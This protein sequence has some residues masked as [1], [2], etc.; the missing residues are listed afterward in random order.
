MAIT[1]PEFVQKWTASTRTERAAAQEHFVDLCESPKRALRQVG[2]AHSVACPLVSRAWRH[3]GNVGATGG[4]VGPLAVRS[5]A[6]RRDLRHGCLATGPGTGRLALWRHGPGGRMLGRA[7]GPA[8]AR[9]SVHAS[10]A[11]ASATQPVATRAA[12]PLI[13]TDGVHLGPRFVVFPLW[14]RTL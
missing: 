4:R 11:R 14:R 13:H 12:H 3:T 5:N 1:L 8:C 2:H 9:P 10:A 7:E 6:G